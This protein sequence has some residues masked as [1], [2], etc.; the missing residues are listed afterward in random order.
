[1]TVGSQKDIDALKEVGRI[2]AITIQEMK[3]QARPGMTTKELDEIGGSVLARYGASSAPPEN[4]SFSGEHLHQH[5][6]G[7][8]PWHSGKSRD[9]TGESH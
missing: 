3:R 6:S 1:M 7:N 4:L 9:S 8:R 2:V 5:Q